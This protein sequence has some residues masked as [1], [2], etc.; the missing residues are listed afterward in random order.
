MYFKINH[1]GCQEHKGLC[2]IRFDLYLDPG[3]Q[4]YD[5]HYV[6]V[7]VIPEGGG[8][9]G[10]LSADGSPLDQTDYDK[11][12][13]GLKRA[14]QNNPFCCHFRH[15]EPEVTDAE[16][17]A[18]G[19]AILKMAYE[20]WKVKKLHLN[21]N[22]KVVFSTNAQKKLDCTNRIKTLKTVDFGIVKPNPKS[23]R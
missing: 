6:E 10:A 19:D 13:V 16:I 20:N 9:Q 18:A 2:E 5:E 15:F 3:D 1:S 7:P 23:T 17:L 21:E 22:P 4:G 8:Y 12:F 11:W 14:W